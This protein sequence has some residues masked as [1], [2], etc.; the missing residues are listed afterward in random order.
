MS[1]SMSLELDRSQPLVSVVTV[2]YNGVDSIAKTL[3]SVLAQ[4][5]PSME[6]VVVDGGSTDGTQQQIEAFGDRIH[7]YVSEPDR[8]VYDAMNKAVSLAAGSWILFM[9]CGDV[10]AADDALVRLSSQVVE[11]HEAIVFGRWVRRESLDVSRLCRPEPAAG[12]FNHQA[13]LYRRALHARFGDYVV[14]PRFT[15]ADYFFFMALLAAGVP[16]AVSEVIV[17]DIDPDGMSSGLQTMAQKTAI[18]YL[19]GRTSRV[20]L[21]AV[22]GL[23]PIYNR[24]KKWSRR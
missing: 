4:D 1:A 24:L 8:G 3:R 21:M 12:L 18:D 11:G 20:K 23:H 13:V 15:T 17:A 7:K 16:H 5:H 14:A 9:N 6:V 10:F 19:L 22:L 2:V